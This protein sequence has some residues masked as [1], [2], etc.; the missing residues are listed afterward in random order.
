L[1]VSILL[2]VMVVDADWSQV[3]ADTCHVDDPG[4]DP[5]KKTGRPQLFEVDVGLKV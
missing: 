3:A 5:P 4:P 1:T 2:L